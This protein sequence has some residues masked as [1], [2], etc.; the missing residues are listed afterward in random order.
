MSGFDVLDKLTNEELDVLV[1]IIV[2]KGWQTESLS[3]D[4]DYK[5]YYPDHKKYVDKIKNELSLM[6]GD[7]LANVARFLM[8]KGSSISYREMLKDV[9]KKL[10][11]E[12]EESTLDG[13]LEYD[14]LATVLKKAF[15]KLSEVEQNIILDILRDNSNEIT[16]NNLFYKIFAD[17]RKEKY[18][19]AVFVSNTLAKTVC[20]RDLSLL[21]DIEVINELK[22][23]TAP[24]GSILMNV[25]KTYDITGPAYRIT[26][27]AIVY[28][29]AMKQIKKN[30]ENKR[31]NIL[32]S[33]F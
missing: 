20:G 12:Y 25:D 31:K 17:D 28:I 3:K 33:F 22:V 11:I 13:E 10:G 2:E 16:A 23:L 27:P 6:G 14:L 19:L 9:C 7:T 15:D 24:L 18:L 29:A 21:K 4:K 5:K 26:L 8:G 32:S 30:D 1:K